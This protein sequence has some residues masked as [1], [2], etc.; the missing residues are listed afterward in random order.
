MSQKNPEKLSKAAQSYVTHQSIASIRCRTKK[1]T[2]EELEGM[3]WAQ[4][5]EILLQLKEEE[6]KNDK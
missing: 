5:H 6:Q 2:Q 4:R 3:T 1:Y